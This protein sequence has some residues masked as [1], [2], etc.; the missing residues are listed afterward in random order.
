M[1][2]GSIVTVVE[3]WGF[4]EVPHPQVQSLAIHCTGGR[5]VLTR[6]VTGAA[7]GEDA[8]PVQA[9]QN[10]LS[11]RAQRTRFDISGNTQV[12][13]L[14]TEYTCENEGELVADLTELCDN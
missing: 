3:V 10:A 14:P 2:H 13:E 8:L 11:L 1:R 5:Y 12:W 4:E 6:R 7:A 9:I